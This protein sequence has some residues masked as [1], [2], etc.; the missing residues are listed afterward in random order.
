MSSI[1][2]LNAL[3]VLTPKMLKQ[4]QARAKAKARELK[5]IR[6]VNDRQARILLKR[7]YDRTQKFKETGDH[8]K[9]KAARTSFRNLMSTRHKLHQRI[10]KLVPEKTDPEFDSP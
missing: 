3:G 7:Y 4:L 6:T 9:N 8:W 2:E 5:L 1:Q 10:S